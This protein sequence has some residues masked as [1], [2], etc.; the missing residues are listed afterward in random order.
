MK[1]LILYIICWLNLFSVLMMQS[2]E[3]HY[4]TITYDPIKWGS[5]KLPWINHR[6]E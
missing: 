1:R 5:T 2:Q 6:H 3:L 4:A